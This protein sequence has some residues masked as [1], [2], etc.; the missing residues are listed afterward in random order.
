MNRVEKKRRKPLRIRD[1]RR[2]CP[3]RIRT[4]TNG[5]KDRCA[6]F[7][8]QGRG[9]AAPPTESRPPGH[10][11]L[12]RSL[13]LVNPAATS[14]PPLPYLLLPATCLRLKHFQPGSSHPFTRSFNQ[15]EP[16]LASWCSASRPFIPR[17]APRCYQSQHQARPARGRGCYALPPPLPG[18]TR[19]RG[20]V[21]NL[22]YSLRIHPGVY[23]YVA[24]A[25]QSQVVAGTRAGRAAI[26]DGIQRSLARAIREKLPVGSILHISPDDIRLPPPRAEPPGGRGRRGGPG[27]QPVRR[28]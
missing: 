4:S 14:R 9:S 5:S 15:A 27:R 22:G 24:Q 12:G 3:Q 25:L 18:V 11:K 20:R 1:L 16:T 28:R 23:A 6:A 13:I 17:P 19:R 26:E 10:R 21:E 2:D 8:P 7:T